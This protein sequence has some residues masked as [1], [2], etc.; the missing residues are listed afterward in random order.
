[1]QFFSF[2]DYVYFCDN[3]LFQELIFRDH[4]VSIRKEIKKSLNWV[5]TAVIIWLV[6]DKLQQE[7]LASKSRGG[8]KD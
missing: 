1:M 6:I 7:G 4:V 3:S 5:I 8:K 2:S